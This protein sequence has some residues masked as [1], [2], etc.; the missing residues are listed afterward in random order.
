VRPP[1]RLVVGPHVYSVS[2]DAEATARTCREQS[3]DLLGHTN[4]RNLRI[5]IDPDQAPSQQRDTMLHEA[6]HAVFE[7]A[8]VQFSSEKEESCIRSLT[9]ALLDLLRRN[10]KLVR[11]LLDD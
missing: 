5:M 8:A 1:R 11:F 7:V 6:L 10:P 9:P 4:H 2:F 3:T